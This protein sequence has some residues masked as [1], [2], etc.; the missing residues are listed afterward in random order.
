MSSEIKVPES[1]ENIQKWFGSIIT[2]PIDI[3]NQI[4]PLSPSGVPIEEEAKIYI[5]KSPFLQPHERIQLYNQQYWWR[6]LSVLH[7]NFPFVTRLFGY[8]EFNQKIGFPYLEKYQPSHWSLNFL[9]RDLLKWAKEFYLDDD[10]QLI[11]D[12]ISLDYAYNNIL[13]AKKSDAFQ[14]DHFSEE[15]LCSRKLKL[16]PHVKL[17]TF[18]YDLFRF[19]SDLLKQEPEYWMEHDFPNLDKG[20]YYFILYR[21]HFNYAVS[22]SISFVA[23]SILKQFENEASIEEVSLWLESQDEKFVNEAVDHMQGWFRDW[24]ALKLLE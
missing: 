9:G 17:F 20:S 13:F 22:D 14:L 10:K 3:D 21:N 1:L 4:M 16:Q 2:R 8:Y 5:S 6:L 11:Y 7:E 12:A 18:N 23:Y 15:E 19:R 24:A